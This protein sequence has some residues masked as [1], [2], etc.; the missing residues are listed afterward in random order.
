MTRMYS[1]LIL[2]LML[3]G[4]GAKELY[5]PRTTTCCRGQLLPH[6][7]IQSALCCGNG[8]F[9][10][11]TE[12]CCDET[13]VKVPIDPEEES[14]EESSDIPSA[15][16]IRGG[17]FR[18]IGNGRGRFPPLFLRYACCGQ[19]TYDLNTELCCDG[20]V[21]PKPETDPKFP[22]FFSCCGSEIY[23]LTSQDCCRGK[24]MSTNSPSERCCGDHIID[25]SKSVCCVEDFGNPLETPVV[26]ER[27]APDVS[28]CGREKINFKKSICCSGKIVPVSSDPQKRSQTLCCGDQAWVSSESEMCCEGKILPRGSWNE[29]CCG[30]KPYDMTTH[31]CC[32]GTVL[33]LKN[34]RT[35]CCGS[36]LYDSSIE[37][38]CY[39]TFEVLALGDNPDQNTCCDY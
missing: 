15:P 1:L 28:C 16:F 36:R 29:T 33:P 27:D 19:V 2:V 18:P 11:R 6:D 31:I 7:S 10:P 13:A 20:K 4:F 38:C 24:V 35:F 8:T 26:F 12:L 14:E 25:Y 22:S 37:S 39:S 30:A 32:N 21:I 17:H 23:N 9:N 5:D 34:N 3:Y